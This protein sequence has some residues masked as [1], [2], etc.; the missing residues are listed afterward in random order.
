MM[1]FACSGCGLCCQFVD[2][3]PELK[4]L[5]SG[6]GICSNY[7]LDT[8]QCQVYETRPDICRVDRQYKLNYAEIFSWEEFTTLNAQACI[9]LQNEHPTGKRQRKT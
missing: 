3:V 6:D 2:K 1:E 9:K 8:R 4:A 5:D 7:D